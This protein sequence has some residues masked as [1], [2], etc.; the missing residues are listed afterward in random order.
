MAKAKGDGQP[1]PNGGESVSG[2][3]RKVFEE[4]PKLL[5]TRSNDE[6]LQRWLKDHPGEKEVS[7]QVR[8]SLMNVKSLL[9]K[10]GRK[11]VRRQEEEQE[12]ATG[13]KAAPRTKV[14]NAL[15]ELEEHIDDCLTVA[16][17]L[18]REGLD[19]VIRLLRQ[20]RNEVVWKI[21]Q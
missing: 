20:A 2:Y 15:E 9:R 3:F 5:K 13:V 14:A 17:L 19:H 6:V 4:S 16:K 18:D 12:R 11:R 7:A 21:G 8:N 10:K 1:K